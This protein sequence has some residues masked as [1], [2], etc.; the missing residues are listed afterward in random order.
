MLSHMAAEGLG[1]VVLQGL[2]SQGPI[3]AEDAS[4]GTKVPLCLR[5]GSQDGREL[6]LCDRPG[7]ASHQVLLKIRRGV[8]CCLALVALPRLPVAIELVVEP[9][10]PAFEEICGAAFKGADVWLEVSEEVA[11][12]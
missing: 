1:V 2:F 11:S 10:V 8:A 7:M 12:V 4:L 6:L 9:V 5:A 3:V